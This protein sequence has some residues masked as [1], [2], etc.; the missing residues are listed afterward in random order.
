MTSTYS[1]SIQKY[2]AVTVM[3]VALCFGMLFA[4]M[5]AQAQSASDLQAFLV[6]KKNGTNEL[7]TKLTGWMFSL[8]TSALMLATIQSL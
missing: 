4:P 6:M 1:F 7:M 8:V 3:G 5:Q 2:V